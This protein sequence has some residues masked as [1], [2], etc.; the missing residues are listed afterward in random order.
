[1]ACITEA[2]QAAGVTRKT[3]SEWCNHHAFQ[4]ELSERRSS[5]LGD[6]H[7]QFEVTKSKISAS[8]EPQCVGVTSSL[9]G[10][11]TVDWI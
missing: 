1:M 11:L 8:P 4:A 6:A 9:E 3:V 7:G 5:A 10:E 2:A